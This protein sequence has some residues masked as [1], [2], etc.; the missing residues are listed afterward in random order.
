MEQKSTP[1]L[2]PVDFL[3]TDNLSMPVRACSI[4]TGI[5]AVRPSF[6]ASSAAD[7]SFFAPKQLAQGISQSL[8]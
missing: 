7:P 6:Q 2:V 5:P 4:W 8:S 1:R 3:V